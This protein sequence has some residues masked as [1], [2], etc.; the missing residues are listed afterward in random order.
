[1][2][3]TNAI[4]LVNGSIKDLQEVKKKLVTGDVDGAINAYNDLFVPNTEKVREEL[5]KI[6]LEG[7]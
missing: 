3:L 7:E 1:M 4:D 6:Q 5:T 2:S